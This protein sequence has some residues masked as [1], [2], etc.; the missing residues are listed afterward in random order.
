MLTE[1]FNKNNLCIVLREIT[2]Y[3]A[4]KDLDNITILCSNAN[5]NL[6]HYI[7][8]LNIKIDILNSENAIIKYQLKEQDLNCFIHEIKPIKNYKFF[9]EYALSPARAKS[10]LMLGLILLISSFFV[11]YKIY[12]LIFGTILLTLAIITFSK[13]IKNK[14]SAQ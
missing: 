12:Y 13:R 9:I 11:L 2:Q 8:A 1:N 4:P 3:Y 6:K 7:N 10:Y 14:N 5:N